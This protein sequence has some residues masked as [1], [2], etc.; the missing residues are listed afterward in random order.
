MAP[1]R[2]ALLTLT[3]QPV[4]SSPQAPIRGLPG[5]QRRLRE[6]PVGDDSRPSA[7]GPWPA[8]HTRIAFAP[9]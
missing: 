2:E 5:H 7:Y 1:E 8:L 6:R 4:V 9:T 3:S